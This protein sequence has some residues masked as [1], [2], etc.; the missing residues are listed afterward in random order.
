MNRNLNRRIHPIAE[1]DGLS[2]K[3][4]VKKTASFLTD[5]GSQSLREKMLKCNILYFYFLYSKFYA[6]IFLVN[7]FPCVYFNAISIILYGFTGLKRIEEYLEAIIKVW[8]HILI[9]NI[10][11]ESEIITNHFTSNGALQEE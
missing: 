4:L 9:E 1:A 10:K 6:R 3:K 2:P 7:K 5:A 8:S 11:V